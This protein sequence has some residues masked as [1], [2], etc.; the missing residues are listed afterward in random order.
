M[1]QAPLDFLHSAGEEHGLRGFVGALLADPGVD[2]P[3]AVALDVG[4][5]PGRG[6]AVVEA[7][8]AW[9]SGLYGADPHEALGV[10]RHA[11]VRPTD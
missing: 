8:A 2:L 3:R 6:W 10:I 7:N 1:P 11:T 5:I 4:V 9:G